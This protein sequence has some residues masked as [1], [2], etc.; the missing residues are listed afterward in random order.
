MSQIAIGIDLGTTNSAIAYVNSYGIPEI[1][2]NSENDG[3]TPSVVYFGENSILVGNEAK[4]MMALGEGSVASFFKRSMGDPNFLLQLGGKNLTAIELSSIILSK[5][6]KDAENFLKKPISSAVITVPAY[7]NNA[8]REATMIAGNKAGLDILQIINEPTAAAIA[9]R[10]NGIKNEEIVMVYDLGG[11]TFDVSLVQINSKETNVLATA[12][13]HNLGGKDW[14]DRIASFLGNKFEEMHG[15]NPL[16]DC[17]TF[18][19]ILIQAEKTKKSLSTRDSIRITVQHKGNKSSIELTKLKFEELTKDLME[20]TIQLCDE[21]L[22]D[23]NM[24]WEDITGILLVGGSTRMPMVVNYVKR[25]S[26]KDHLTGINVDEAVAQGAAILASIKMEEKTKNNLKKSSLGFRQTKDVMSHSLGMI[27]ISQDQKKYIN[28]IILPK[29]CHIPSEATRPYQLKAS[30]KNNNSL[31]I[32]MTQG[33]T[34]DPKSCCYLGKYHI[35]NIPSVDNNPIILDITY[36]YDS[37][38]MVQVEAK[39]RSDKNILHISVEALPEDMSWVEKPPQNHIN[40][41]LTT[42]LAI[43]LSGSMSGAP[44]AEAQ[45]AAREFLHQSDLSHSSIGLISF[46]DKIKV[47]I[48]ACQNA[49]LIEKAISNLKIGSVGY[50]NAAIPFSDISKI[51]K[52]IT[53]LKYLIILTDGVWFDQ[54]TAIEESNITKLEGIEIIAIGFG[55]ADEKFL[56][57]I[58]STEKGSYFAKAG[59]LVDTFGTIAR[60][61]TENNGI[62]EMKKGKL[63]FL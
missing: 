19:E 12:G 30:I 20:R 29:N 43:D 15:V 18:N 46:A 11:G 44:L 57:K 21:V 37:N 47:N 41:H 28:S 52:N 31:D 60:E 1:I 25:M 51:L 39:N 42:Y 53:G 45:E 34:D 14:D 4:N 22:K 9:Y 40:N 38:G 2:P 23:K 8:Q 10:I 5:L 7:F 36:K 16:D 33:E 58:A 63:R 55:G 62:T 35:S 56:A 49:K 59:E 54:K 32:F 13:D 50:G 24:H 48:E 17:E 3:I 6:K 61:L 27:A 26:N